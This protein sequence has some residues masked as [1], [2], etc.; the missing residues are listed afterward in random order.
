MSV[1]NQQGEVYGIK[2][3]SDAKFLK[4]PPG[5]T[6]LNNAE[7][8]S[9]A[10]VSV[11]DRVLA[12]GE[13]LAAEKAL[14]ATSLVLMT[15]AEIA[16]KR[17]ADRAEWL[18]RGVAGVVTA[19]APG[20]ITLR[21]G[22]KTVT[23]ALT[24]RTRFRRYAPDSVRFD[25]AKPS[26]FAEVNKGD[27]LRALGNKSE[28]GGKFEAQ[29]IV[30]GTFRTAAG[31]VTQVDR[32]SS[33]IRMK[34]TGTG[35]LLA[36]HLTADSNFRRLPQGGSTGIDQ[37]PPATL[38]E[39]KTGEGVIVSSTLGSK[40]DELTAIVLVAGAASPAAPAGRPAGVVP[41]WNMDIGL[42]Q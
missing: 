25:D 1:A 23:V 18:K 35:K 2:F 9:L 7:A 10:D 16:K 36:V 21:Q 20:Q 29:E 27:Q 24:G 13:F 11:G 26:S 12:R 30:F 39:L 32:A 41:N 6:G 14:I 42:P 31:T 22:A 3:L 34:E 19:V 15:K 33:L 28:D 40:P 4:V 8:I 17:E 5:A 38:A 37:L